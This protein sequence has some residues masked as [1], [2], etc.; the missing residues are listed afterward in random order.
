MPR[1]SWFAEYQDKTRFAQL[2]EDGKTERS[3]DH[4]PNRDSI[5]CFCLF[6][7]DTKKPVFTLYLDDGYKLIYRRRVFKAIGQPDKVFYL[8]G[9]RKTVGGECVQSIAYV[10][11]ETCY[12]QMAGR[13]R[14][15]HPLFDIPVL[16]D[17][18]KVTGE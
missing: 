4:I 7:V 8:V 17:F 10:H 15:D 5:V 9:S 6:E 13:F 16:R 12:V 1:L 18:E 11:E 14:A 3:Y 2:A